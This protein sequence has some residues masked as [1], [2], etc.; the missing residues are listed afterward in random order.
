MILE[1]QISPVRLQANPSS[2]IKSSEY[3]GRLAAL[4]FHTNAAHKVLT[5]RL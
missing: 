1:E 5:L 3:V 2:E 4:H